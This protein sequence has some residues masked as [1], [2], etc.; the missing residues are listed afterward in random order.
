M[1][2]I[3]PIIFQKFLKN[4]N[5]FNTPLLKTNDNKVGTTKY[6]PPVS[7]EWKNSLFFYNIKK[8]NNLP[9]FDSFFDKIIT[10]FFNS[11]FKTSKFIKKA[12]YNSINKSFR[13]IYLSKS[14]LKHTYSK[15]IVTIY[16]YNKQKKSLLRKIKNFSYNYFFKKV[17]L[18]SY[19]LKRYLD[20]SFSKKIKLKIITLNKL[21]MLLERY[22][23]KFNLNKFKFEEGFLSILANILSKFYKKK[24]EFNIVDLKSVVY[25][26]DIFTKILGLKSKKKRISPV[27]N[28]KFLL[29]KVILPKI[30]KVK[31]K[32]NLR[33]SVNMN[34]LENKYKNLDLNSIKNSNFD[35]WLNNIYPFYNTN[36]SKKELH[37]IIFNSIHYKNMGGIRLEIKGRLTRRYRADRA[38]LKVRWKGGL[39][40]IDSSYKRLPS[41]MKRGYTE[42]NLDYSLF[43]SKRHIG[44]FAVKGWISGK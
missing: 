10:A 6:F 44:A 15:V 20:K 13:Q 9:V 24:I 39:K 28:M 36:E 3:Y 1:K 41:I 34:L 38:K 25:N 29:K 42:Y 43:T 14:E 27:R 17:S 12:K 21:L 5:N 31:E 2:K 33:K 22:K 26:S 30:N 4:N 7:K 8:T 23:F 16:I 40:N 19:T 11:Y 32:N 18:T 35:E 37:K